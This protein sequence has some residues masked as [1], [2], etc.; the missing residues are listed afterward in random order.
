[1]H[2]RCW[3]V[4]GLTALG[5]ACGSD[6][7]EPPGEYLRSSVERLSQSSDLSEVRALTRNNATFAVGLHAELPPGENLFY[8]PHSISTALAMTYAGAAGETAQEMR[9]TLRFAQAPEVLHQAFNTLDQRLESRGRGQR[10][11]DGSPF[12]LRVVNALFAQR[13]FAVRD[14]Y[15][16]DMARYYG[17]GLSLLD[18][19]TETEPSRAA[20]NRWVADVTEDRIDELIPRGAVTPDTVLVLTNAV[21]FNAAWKDAF[22]EES[23]QVG[24]FERLDGTSVDVPLMRGQVASRIHTGEGWIA[25]EIPYAGDE[26]SM[27]LVVPDDLTAFEAQ[28][29]AEALDRIVDGLV[30]AEISVTMP[31]FEMRSKLSLREML[32]AMG[33]ASA[34]ELADFSNLTP[35]T[36]LAITD[37]LHEGFVRVNE[38]GTEAAAATAVIVGR[39]SVPQEVAATRPFLFFIRDVETGAVLFVGRVVDPSA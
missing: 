19:V 27:V 26:V 21:Y 10:G 9:E 13:G 36:G 35:E 15:L 2:P 29:D 6:D 20:I 12:R 11:A 22:R 25:A 8:S 24:A 5:F 17:A 18:F 1:M 33:M 16:D 38:K 14:T 28:L 37:V 4:L 30:S 7:P 23:T 3:L 39:V 32:S 31:R 34:F